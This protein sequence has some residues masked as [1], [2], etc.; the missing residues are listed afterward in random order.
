MRADGEPGAMEIGDQALFVVHGSERGR[1]LGLGV[2]FEQGAGEAD[3]GFDLPQGVA[4]V[5][6]RV[7]SPGYRVPNCRLSIVDG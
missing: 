2:L 7:A 6:L 3:S 1:G 4:A 5:E